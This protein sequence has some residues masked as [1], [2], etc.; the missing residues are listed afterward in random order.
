MNR[1]SF[2]KTSTAAGLLSGA[3][4]ARGQTE[5]VV[6][7]NAGKVRG[8]V[9]DKGIAFKG[10]PYGSPTGGGGRFM[11][12]GKVQPWTGV[13]DAFELG[14]QAPQNSAQILLPSFLEG[15]TE[16]SANSEDCLQ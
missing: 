13:R 3:V 7:T 9:F 1:R 8:R 4:V 15:M 10:I 14:A 16:N 5:P 12:P 11:P 2:L 6:D